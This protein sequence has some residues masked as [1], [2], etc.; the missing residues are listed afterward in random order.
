MKTYEI[1]D[2]EGNRVGIAGDSSECLIWV[3]LAHEREDA[4]NIASITPAQMRRLAAMLIKAADKI[5]GRTKR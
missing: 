1:N 2:R 3:G 4:D 5:E